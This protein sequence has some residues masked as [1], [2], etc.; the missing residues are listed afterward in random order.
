VCS[1]HLFHVH[2]HYVLSAV[3][4]TELDEQPGDRSFLRIKAAALDAARSH[5]PRIEAIDVELHF[6]RGAAAVA[7][8]DADPGRADDA[9]ACAAHLEKVDSPLSRVL[10]AQLRGALCAARGQRDR[11]IEHLRAAAAA[12]EVNGM[13]AHR[14]AAQLRL[15]KVLADREG[16]TLVTSADRWFR[17]HG[18]IDVDRFVGILS[19]VPPA[20]RGSP[21]SASA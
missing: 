4:S 6:L 2:H 17:D 15:G 18:V 5:L 19:P 10:S 20:R 11:A 1:S 8:L 12:A 13:A 9:E 16:A 21:D 14:A 3:G 7:G